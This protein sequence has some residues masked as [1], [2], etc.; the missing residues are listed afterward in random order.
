M[1]HIAPRAEKCVHEDKGKA[2]DLALLA[3][4]QRPRPQV[5]IA[6]IDKVAEAMSHKG[7]G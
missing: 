2:P 1:A 7:Y 4:K 3:E 5:A 6:A